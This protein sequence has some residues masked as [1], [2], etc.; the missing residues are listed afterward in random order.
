MERKDFEELYKMYAPV[1][2]RTAFR[3]VKNDAD[4]LDI[5]QE[6]FIR[7]YNNFDKFKRRSSIQ[8]WMYRIVMNLCYDYFRRKKKV[9]FVSEDEIFK[10]G[11]EQGQFT[12]NNLN[13]FENLEDKRKQNL[14]KALEHLTLRQRTVFNFR[15]YEELSYEEIAS[16]MKIKVGTAK[17]T[18]FQAVEKIKQIMK[19][20]E[21]NE[22]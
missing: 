3:M 16:I 1:L 15:I 4:A 5:V 2:Y 21:K 7:I 8:T 20:M 17:A 12:K 19:E 22:M 10:D 14:Q 11:E 18:F 13:D 6:A 9:T